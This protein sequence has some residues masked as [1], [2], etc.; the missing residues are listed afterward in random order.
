MTCS[1]YL[2]SFFVLK[3]LS[4]KERA[5]CL[6]RAWKTRR[7]VLSRTLVLNVT[8]LSVDPFHDLTICFNLDFKARPRFCE[9]RAWFG[10]YLFLRVQKL[11]KSSRSNFLSWSLGII[12]NPM[13]FIRMSIDIGFFFIRWDIFTIA[14]FVRLARERQDLKHFFLIRLLKCYFATIDI[15]PS[16]LNSLATLRILISIVCIKFLSTTALRWIV[17]SWFIIL[18]RR[19]ILNASNVFK[20]RNSSCLLM[21]FIK[22][23]KSLF[24]RTFYRWC[25]LT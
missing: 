18:M 20:N 13:N 8:I 16:N 22:P 9:R 23:F 11:W 1:F 24:L 6:S 17:F 25:N 19:A 5:H 7:F 14:S 15:A 21:A 10:L 3:I 2:S 4:L 12:W